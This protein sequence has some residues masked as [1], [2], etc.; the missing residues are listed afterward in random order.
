VR[1]TLEKG[2][3]VEG[4]TPFSGWLPFGRH[5]L[6]VQKE[7]HEIAEQ[8]LLVKPGTTET[9]A[10]ELRAEAGVT[11]EPAA[12]AEVGPAP[13]EGGE[14]AAAPV[15][16]A[17]AAAEPGGGGE[18]VAAAPEPPAVEPGPGSGTGWFPWATMGLGAAL[19]GG[20]AVFGRLSAA[21]EEARD[22]VAG[23]ARADDNRASY[24]D[25][26]AHD[27]AARS[28]ALV[29][30]VLYG[31]GGVAVVAGIVVLLVGGEEPGEAS[32]TAVPVLG[33]NVAGAAIVWRPGP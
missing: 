3:P 29:A 13:A 6:E 10:L 9:V 19:L 31:A 15:A 2:E 4:V 12:R 28:R 23:D 11:P 17:A 20:G 1:V 27:E 26:E 8:L 16:E 33:P 22:S 30:N 25:W 7:G 32:V 18:E 21:E 5:R 24:D 14:G